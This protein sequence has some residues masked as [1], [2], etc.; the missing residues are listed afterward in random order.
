MKTVKHILTSVF[1]VLGLVSF[2]QVGVG[3]QSPSTT[4][5]VVGTNHTTAPGALAAADG[6]TVPRVTTNMTDGSGATNGVTAGQLVYSTHTSSTGFWYWTGVTSGS[7]DGAFWDPVGGSAS[8]PDFTVGGTSMLDAS[9]G[10][11][12]AS[13]DQVNNIFIVSTAGFG[14]NTVTL[15]TANATNRGRVVLVV[16]SLTGGASFSITNAYNSGFTIGQ[17]DSF[18]YICDGTQ[19]IKG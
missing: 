5:D 9:G 8:G 2:A 16:N 11:A 14:S 6:V 15:P 4:L 3:T 13:S 7:G 17:G 12:D 1:L 10:S 18:I 19:W